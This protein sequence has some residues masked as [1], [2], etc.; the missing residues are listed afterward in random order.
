MEPFAFNAFNTLVPPSLME[1]APS[2][3]PLVLE[4][5]GNPLPNV[6]RPSF[7]AKPISIDSSGGGNG[8]SSDADLS[9]DGRFVVFDSFASNLGSGDTNGDRDVFVH[10]RHMGKTRA[11]SVDVSGKYRWGA[12][13]NPSL[14][15]DGRY[16]AF[17]STATFGGVDWSEHDTNGKADIYLKDLY[18]QQII[19]VSSRYFSV[20][21][22]DSFNPA[23]SANGRYIA[24][25]STASNLVAGDYNNAPD[26]FVFLNEPGNPQIERIAV[27]PNFREGNDY[28]PLSYRPSISA[29]GRYIAF[30]S[31]FETLVATAIDNEVAD[32]FIYDRQTQ[33]TRRVSADTAGNAG[34]NHSFNASIS[35]NGR[36]VVYDSSA[37]NLVANDTNGVSDIFVYDLETGTNQRLS[38]DSRGNQGNGHSYQPSISADGQWVT[39]LSKSTNLANLRNSPAATHGFLHNRQTGETRLVGPIDPRIGN[40]IAPSLAA[41]GQSMAFHSARS[42]LGPGFTQVSGQDI[43][44]T[45][46]MA[47]VTVVEGHDGITHA[48]FT[49]TLSGARDYSVSVGYAVADGTAQAGL[50]YGAVVGLDAP[51]NRG[52]LVF[53]PGQTTASFELPIFGDRQIEADETIA[54]YFFDPV[55]AYVAESQVVHTIGNDDLPNL[56]I[57]NVTQPE[58]TSTQVSTPFEFAVSLDAPSP[59]PITVTYYTSNGTAFAGSDY[60]ATNGTLV[61]QPWETRQTIQVIGVADDRVEA[62]ET[63]F[64]NLVGSTRA[65]IAV[66]RGTGTILNDDAAP[67]TL[68]EGT[69]QADLL[70]GD[71]FA[72]TINGRAGA[73]TLYGLGG[74]DT[75]NGG[76]GNDAI[77]GGEGDDLINGNS[78]NDRLYGG[79]GRD[80]INGGSEDDVIYGGGEA[81]ILIGGT[82]NDRVVYSALAEAGDTISDFGNGAD[83]LDLRDLFQAIGYT[84]NQTIADEYLR[85]VGAG[86]NTQVQIDAKDGAGF[87][88]L[89]TLN[90]VGPGQLA[91]GLTLLV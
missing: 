7:W 9:A 14:S 85:L 86:G 32:V 50:D 59:D 13:S 42:D 1:L 71:N 47:A 56:F 63:F 4:A 38:V 44:P 31:I 40:P 8:H 30:T 41:N 24:F 51:G 6:P 68:L 72:N 84:G 35:D 67:I 66:G 46:A 83:V 43:L 34:N 39:F 77:Y 25:E 69:P 89:T 87:V 16:V 20:G 62:N 58:G 90:G 29:D 2:P 91:I 61:F 49:G 22:G 48:T 57:D 74:D 3:D 36:Y 15:A 65:A 64:V 81:D 19:P 79:N 55:D 27:G 17:Q 75:L 26:I 88:T 5:P 33:Q 45:F 52:R 18:N 60:A 54:L 28:T 21:N 53:A 76:A 78:E 11:V 12:S 37:N 23:I 10:D 70:T 73:D 82:G 80:R